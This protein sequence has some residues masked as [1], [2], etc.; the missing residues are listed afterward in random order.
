MRTCFK[1]GF[2]TVG[3]FWQG[4]CCCCEADD[5]W[6]LVLHLHSTAIICSL[7]MTQQAD[8]AVYHSLRHTHTHTSPSRSTTWASHCS[9]YIW[10]LGVERLGFHY[11]KSPTLMQQY[12][13]VNSVLNAKSIFEIQLTQDSASEEGKGLKKA[14]FPARISTVINSE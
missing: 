5:V 8:A 12:S 4:Q 9:G 14:F 6:V 7:L 10:D 1:V 13:C 3:W 2:F 11:Q